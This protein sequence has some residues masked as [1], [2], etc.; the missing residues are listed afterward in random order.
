MNVDAGN[1]NSGEPGDGQ[2]RIDRRDLTAGTLPT[3]AIPKSRSEGGIGKV[4]EAEGEAIERAVSHAIGLYRSV[5]GG[6]GVDPFA[7]LPPAGVRQSSLSWSR[8]GLASGSR[9]PNKGGY[10]R[11]SGIATR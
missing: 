5:S 8:T 1:G 9:M 11:T 3:L 6:L 10:L 7:G 2:P 4:T